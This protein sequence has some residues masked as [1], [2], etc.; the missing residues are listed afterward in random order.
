MGTEFDK[1]II[2]V[3][4]RFNAMKLHDHVAKW[5]TRKVD[6]VGSKDKPIMVR[7]VLI[8]ALSLTPC[9]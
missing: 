5:T 9:P 3:V 2:M 7:T 6:L 8:H 1:G 4:G